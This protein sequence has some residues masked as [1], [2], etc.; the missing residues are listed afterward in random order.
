MEY[1]TNSDSSPIPQ[2]ETKMNFQ[3]FGCT[4]ESIIT[5]RDRVISQLKAKE[6][7]NQTETR[8]KV[9]QLRKF[10]R[11]LA[12]IIT[13]HRKRLSDL[14]DLVD[15]LN[16]KLLCQ[17]FEKKHLLDEI[18]A[19]LSAKYTLRSGAHTLTF[20]RNIFESIE[21][22]SSEEIESTNPDEQ[23]HLMI[24]RLQRELSRRQELQVQL[25]S[26]LQRKQQTE[27][28]LQAKKQKIE[29][30]RNH[31]QNLLKVSVLFC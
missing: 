3:R 13:D 30:L 31:L 14:K 11:H 19:C 24:K 9:L 23:H 18:K 5:E 7:S 10:N 20:F 17:K 2:N 12:N 26:I 22:E 15:N 29:D 28:E 8:L 4:L 21:L 16:S 27:A 25:I 6:A 1:S